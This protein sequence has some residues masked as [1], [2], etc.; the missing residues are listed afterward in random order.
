ML[1]DTTDIVSSTLA[2]ATSMLNYIGL[3]ITQLGFIMTTIMVSIGFTASIIFW[4]IWKSSKS[5]S[6]NI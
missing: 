2:G 4:L 1:F 3:P 5:I 6:R